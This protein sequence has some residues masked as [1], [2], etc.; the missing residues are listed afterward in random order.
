MPLAISV[1]SRTPSPSQ[2]AP[3]VIAAVISTTLYEQGSFGSVPLVISVASRTPSPSQSTV[4]VITSVISTTLY[5]QG[6]FGSVPLAVSVASRTPSPSV[7]T[8]HTLTVTVT[9]V[10]SS[11]E[12]DDGATPVTKTLKVVVEVKLPVGKEIVPPSPAIG[13]PIFESSA[14]FLS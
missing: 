4:A 12:H 6:S 10:K 7:S 8:A 11:F 5:E 2:S 9:I 13:T 3:E 14:S 1:A